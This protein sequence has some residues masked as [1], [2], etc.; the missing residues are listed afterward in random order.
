MTDNSANT[1]TITSTGAPKVYKYNPFGYTAQSST[2]YTPSL[3][4]GSAYFDGTGDYLIVPANAA[5]QFTGD[6]TVDFWVYFNTTTGPQD[7]IGNYVTNAAADWL[8]EFYLNKIQYYP[9]SSASYVESA[10]VY[11]GTW[12]HVAAVRYGTTC[13]LYIN[14]VSQG[15]PLTFSGTLGDA[16]RPVYIGARSGGTIDFLNGYMSDIRIVKGTAVY[17]ANFIP[18]PAPITAVANTTLLLNC[19]SGGIVDTHGSSVLE[20][21]GNTQLN[22]SV[23]KYGNASISFKGSQYLNTQSPGASLV[24]AF[25]TS[26]F[27]IEMWVYPTAYA[28]ALG[29]LIDTRPSGTSSTSTYTLL[30]IAPS[31]SLQY[32]TGTGGLQVISGGIIP[33]NTWTHVALARSGTSTKMFIN[34]AQTGSTYTDTQ[35]YQCGANRPI[36]GTDGNSPL[37]TGYSFI[38]Y[39]DDL[40][41]TK[42]FA[43]YNGAFPTPSTLLTL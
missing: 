1:I 23:K 19:T 6:Y 30:G 27:T 12:N 3:N 43:R 39:I 41:I 11:P 31:G 28:A 14:G 13:S 24:A 25:G 8:L 9:S 37:N 26:D 29:L 15:T 2:S 7:M 42:G 35:S 22:T 21:L 32:W 17:K 36:I 33:L 40:R 38:G 10:T 5:F 4:G 34:G 20:T 16:T 18:P